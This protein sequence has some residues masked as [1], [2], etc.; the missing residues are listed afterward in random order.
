MARFARGLGAHYSTFR[1]LVRYDMAD[2]AVASESVDWIDHALPMLQELARQPDVECLPERFEKYRD[3][4]RER[5]YNI[6]YGVRFNT[7]ITPNGKV[8]ICPNRREFP[9]SYIGDLS[10]ESFSDIWKRHPGQ[11]ADF[12]KCRVFCRLHMINEAVWPVFRRHEHAEFI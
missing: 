3:W 8:W 11:W 1:P 7:T 9:D 6:C 5:P 10:E 12:E 2:P 4:R